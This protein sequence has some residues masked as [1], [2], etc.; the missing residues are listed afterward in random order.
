MATYVGRTQ[1]HFCDQDLDVGVKD[2]TLLPNMKGG[3]KH[4][5]RFSEE[6]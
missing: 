3:G 5:R 2:S 6:R 4:F 1:H